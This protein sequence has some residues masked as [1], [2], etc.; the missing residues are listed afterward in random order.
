M[1]G[2]KRYTAF[3]KQASLIECGIRMLQK[4]LPQPNGWVDGILFSDKEQ[5]SWYEV[6]VEN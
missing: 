5:I 6:M 3:G 4:N 2:L 1:R